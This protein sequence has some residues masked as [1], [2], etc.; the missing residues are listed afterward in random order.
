[1]N[2]TQPRRVEG[3]R[4][5]VPEQ[6][7]VSSA[8]EAYGTGADH[9]PAASTPAVLFAGRSEQDRRGKAYHGTARRQQAIGDTEGITMTNLTGFGATDST[10]I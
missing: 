5:G 4:S 3:R 7:I 9:A 10:D 8:L 6:T 1:M 2:D